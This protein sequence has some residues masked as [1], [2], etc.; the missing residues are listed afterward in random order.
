MWH[1]VV[2]DVSRKRGGLIFKCRHVEWG[3]G[4]V[5][6]YSVIR[7]H[8]LEERRPYLHNSESR[9]DSQINR[10][11]TKSSPRIVM[12]VMQLYPHCCYFSLWFRHPLYHHRLKHTQI[13]KQSWASP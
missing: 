3:T 13:K 7:R 5:D 12:F 10:N 1:R 6:Q 9:K 4:H 11:V 8:I 2:Y